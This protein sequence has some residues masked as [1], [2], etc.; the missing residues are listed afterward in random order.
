MTK[1]IIKYEIY[2]LKN[3][4]IVT[5]YS[6]IIPKRVENSA[7]MAQIAG[8]QAILFQKIGYFHSTF[9]TN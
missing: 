2:Y 1:K 8:I 6:K 4:D 9:D 5:K 7:A 3:K